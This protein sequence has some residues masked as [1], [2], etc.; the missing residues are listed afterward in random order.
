MFFN[1]DHIISQ[2]FPMISAMQIE[3]RVATVNKTDRVLQLTLTQFHLVQPESGDT[4]SA[5]NFSCTGS[6]VTFHVVAAL[7]SRSTSQNC[8]GKQL[9]RYLRNRVIT[10][11]S[12]L[13]SFSCAA[14]DPTVQVPVKS[15]EHLILLMQ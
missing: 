1:Y 4:L 10:V 15:T 5:G 9:R 8:S 3:G 11:F 2:T 12:P 14:S 6:D 13:S 7:G